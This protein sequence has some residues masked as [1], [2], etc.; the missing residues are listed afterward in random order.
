MPS[1]TAPHFTHVGVIQEREHVQFV[2]ADRPLE[3][4]DDRPSGHVHVGGDRDR[5]LRA[6]VVSLVRGPRLRVVGSRHGLQGQLLRYEHARFHCTDVHYRKRACGHTTVIYVVDHGDGKNNRIARRT[7][8]AA[9]ER[10]RRWRRRMRRAHSGGCRKKSRTK[11]IEMFSDVITGRAEGEG[12]CVCIN[13]FF[14]RLLRFDDVKAA[15]KR[16][17]DKWHPGD[18]SGAG[19]NNY[20]T[21]AGCETHCAH[22]ATATGRRAT[23][24]RTG[25]LRWRRR[26]RRNT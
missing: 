26:R 14:S 7:G 3:R 24:T 9:I 22:T 12:Q 8:S 19:K 18:D 15:T 20:A 23:D 25:V 6:H 5:W 21:T 13:L 1:A 2:H 16:Q 10:R 11:A 4:V 17:N